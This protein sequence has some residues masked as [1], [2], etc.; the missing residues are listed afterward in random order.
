MSLKNPDVEEIVSPGQETTIKGIPAVITTDHNE[1][2][3]YWEKSGL[4]NTTLLH[5]DG[6]NDLGWAYLKDI[7][8]K[9]N[10]MDEEEIQKQYYNILDI[11]GFISPA[12]HYGVVSSVYWLNPHSENKTLQYMGSLSDK[13]RSLKT[14][15]IEEGKVIKEKGFS[16]KRICWSS[17]YLQPREDKEGEIIT[18]DKLKITAQN[19]FILDIDLDAF[20]CDREMHNV[21]KDYDG[22]NGYEERINKTLELIKKLR[23]PNL[24]TIARSKGDKKVWKCYRPDAIDMEY[25]ALSEKFVPDEFS[26]DVE[27]RLI[28]GLEGIF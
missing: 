1:V 15:V 5:I 3:F 6:H 16:W 22:V 21:P 18:S 24:I 25:F 23:K 7:L 13:K 14:R 10:E 20:C 4:V 28:Q 9:R 2:F 8:R 27:E 19:P 26:K 11:A 12:V 17:K